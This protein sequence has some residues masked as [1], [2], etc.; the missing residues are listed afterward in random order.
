MQRR[1]NQILT[2]RD[3]VLALTE[4]R[5]LAERALASAPEY[6]RGYQ[7]GIAVAIEI[8]RALD[9]MDRAVSTQKVERR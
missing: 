1:N 3:L 8:V 4:A 5:T 7:E 6:V 9:N 2:R